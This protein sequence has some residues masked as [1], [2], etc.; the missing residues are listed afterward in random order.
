ME[1]KKIIDDKYIYTKIQLQD[2]SISDAILVAVDAENVKFN[3]G[4]NLVEKLAL[5]ASR[6]IYQDTGINFDK[7]SLSTLASASKT[8]IASPFAISNASFKTADFPG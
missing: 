2:G 1:E 5:R 4:N 6:K 7:K 3:D 8:K